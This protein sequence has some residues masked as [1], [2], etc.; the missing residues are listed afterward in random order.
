MYIVD[1]DNTSSVAVH[2]KVKRSSAD[3]IFVEIL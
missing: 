3:S 2:L 1:I